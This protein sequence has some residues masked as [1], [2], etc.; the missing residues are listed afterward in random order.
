MVLEASELDIS[1]CFGYSGAKDE[2][3]LVQDTQESTGSLT[4][5]FAA[6][7][8]QKRAKTEQKTANRAKAKAKAKKSKV[9]A[10]GCVFGDRIIGK[11]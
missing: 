3:L 5:S 9:G 1:V 6:L 7:G 11:M 10:L 2:E 8:V 4:N